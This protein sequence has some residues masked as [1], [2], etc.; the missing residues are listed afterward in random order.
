MRNLRY[1]LISTLKVCFSLFKIKTA[2]GFQYRIASLAGA[3]TSIFWVLIEITVYIIFYKYANNKGAGLSSGLAL[4]Q[5]VSYSWLTQVLFLMQPMNIDSEFLTKITNGD[6]GIEMCR[7]LDLYS[8]WFSKTAASRLTPIFWRGSIIVIFGFLMPAGYRLSLPSTI[9]GFV[10]MLISFISAF[11]LCTSYS[12][13]TC[14]VRMNI[15]WGD[16]PTYIMML[17]GGVLSGGYLPLQLWPKFLQRFLLFQPFAGYLD[18]PLRFYIGTLYISDALWAI[19]IQ[20]IWIVAFIF[21]G[22]LLMTK[23][24]KNIVVQGG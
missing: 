3:S 19:G 16:G 23:Q 20:L 4:K 2:E 10:C 24:L 1:R 5:V 18:I 21:A 15:P 17:I 11:F 6:I 8:H 13:L 9:T 7:P 12:M 22:K 14:V